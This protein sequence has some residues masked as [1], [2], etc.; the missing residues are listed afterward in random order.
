[1]KGMRLIGLAVACALMLPLVGHAQKFKF[2]EVPILAKRV[3]DPVL[4]ALISDEQRTYSTR[5]GAL[6]GYNPELN[7]PNT[8][9]RYVPEGPADYTFELFTEG[10]PRQEFTIP[11]DK[12]SEAGGVTGAVSKALGALSLSQD[13]YYLASMMYV[14]AGLRVYD[15]AGKLL[16]TVYLSD[17]TREFGSWV[18]GSVEE[19]VLTPNHKSALRSSKR[20]TVERYGQQPGMK[21]SVSAQQAKSVASQLTALA[22]RMVSLLF[23]RTS[24]DEFKEIVLEPKVARNFPEEAALADEAHKLYTTWASNT[25]NEEVCGQLLHLA[26]RFRQMPRTE[27]KASNFFY[28]G[29][30]ALCRLMAGDIKDAPSTMRA[31]IDEKPLKLSLKTDVTSTFTLLLN[32]YLPYITMDRALKGGREANVASVLLPARSN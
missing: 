32:T 7:V 3:P 20:E 5:A 15:T 2:E 11:E 13:E 17:Q 19:P 14:T 22:E 25:R 27:S 4:P 8:K 31:A 26:G 28:L 24:I 21:Q 16:L 18:G 30:E 10:E 23:A 29:H 6:W 12:K 9:L 1:M